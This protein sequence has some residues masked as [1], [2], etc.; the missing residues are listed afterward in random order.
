MEI[1]L[2][3]FRRQNETLMGVLKRIRTSGFTTDEAQQLFYS[4]KDR[5]LEHIGREEREFHPALRELTKNDVYLTKTVNFFINEV[6]QSSRLL[7]EFL[8]R[9]SEPCRGLQYAEDFGTVY[10]GLL[11]RVRLQEHALYNI[12]EETK[13]GKPSQ[14]NLEN[15]KAV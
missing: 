9:Y 11:Q 12:Y 13:A 10:A 3:G 1:N 2:Q 14:V 5:F 4:S 8:D 7:V 15:A 6:D